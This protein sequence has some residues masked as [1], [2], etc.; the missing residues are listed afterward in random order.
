VREQKRTIKAN[1]ASDQRYDMAT[2]RVRRG[3][4]ANTTQPSIYHSYGSLPYFA[5]G[6]YPQYRNSYTKWRRRYAGGII[7]LSAFCILATITATAVYI[8]FTGGIKWLP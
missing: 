1:P 7:T 6:T 2:D 3:L 5:W 4:T 8:G